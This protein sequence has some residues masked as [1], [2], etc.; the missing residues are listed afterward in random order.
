[1]NYV[2]EIEKITD[3]YNISGHCYGLI[4]N[5]H[6]GIWTGSANEKVHHYGNGG[7]AKHT[8]EVVSLCEAAAKF[9]GDIIN[10]KELLLAA[11]WHDAGKLWDYEWREEDGVMRWCSSKQKYTIYHITRSA[12]EFMK[13]A[14]HIKDPDID[15]ENVL[16]N[17]LAHHGQHEWKSPVTPQTKEAVILHMCDN[18]SAR[19]DDV[20][21]RREW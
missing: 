15:A 1:M 21:K 3:R 8:W 17:I 13:I 18:M 11:V 20:E 7:L 9:Y 14:P 12:I 5:G 19:V 4:H 10:I 6:F 16:H 2:E